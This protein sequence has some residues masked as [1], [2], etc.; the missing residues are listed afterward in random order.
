MAFHPRRLPRL[1]PPPI[2]SEYGTQA[3]D[4]DTQA[5]IDQAQSQAALAQSQI[6]Q[7]AFAPVQ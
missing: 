3:A 1:V 2:P 5:L 7:N 4:P 6:T